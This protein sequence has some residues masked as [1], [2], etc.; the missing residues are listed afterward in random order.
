MS[1]HSLFLVD[2]AMAMLL[3]STVKAKS[4]NGYEQHIQKSKFAPLGQPNKA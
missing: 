4:T 3:T 2:N 1:M